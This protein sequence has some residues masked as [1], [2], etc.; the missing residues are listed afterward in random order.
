[1]D[2]EK[3][4]EE[5]IKLELLRDSLTDEIQKAH[6]T[7]Q[8]GMSHRREIEAKLITLKMKLKAMAK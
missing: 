8:R 5:I 3:A 4:K 7:I 2:I 6:V 1:M